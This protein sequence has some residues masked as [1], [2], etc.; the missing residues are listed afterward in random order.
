MDIPGNGR[1]NDNFL[2]LDLPNTPF[3]S[4]VDI[5]SFYKSN[6]TVREY[7]DVH[8]NVTEFLKLTN[9]SV[10]QFLL[11]CKLYAAQVL[12]LYQTPGYDHQLPHIDTDGSAFTFS[13]N[14]VFC[15][16]ECTYNWYVPTDITKP[17]NIT[18]NG[19]G[20]PYVKFSY[21]ELRLVESTQH[22]GPLILNTQR[23]HNARAHDPSV[24]RLAVSFRFANRFSGM[25]ELSTRISK[26]VKP[27]DK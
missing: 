7:I 18:K 1:M 12:V 8:N 15:D 26:F 3:R 11:E 24:P 5:K 20:L 9:S 2:L 10:K 17:F 6:E 13:M 19:V 21:D 14:W 22:K 4:D 27:Q 16:G 25:Q 23:I